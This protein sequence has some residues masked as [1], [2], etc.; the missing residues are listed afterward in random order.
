MLI[1]SIIDLFN[2]LDKGNI[3]NAKT[4]G[5]TKDLHFKEGQYNLIM[6]I[7]FIPYVVTA[8]FIAIL[9]K[10]YGPALSLTLM[11]ASFGSMTLLVTAVYNFSGM[12]ALRWFVGMSE[13]A[14]FPLV[15]Y[16]LTMFYRRTE[17]ARRLAIFYG[18]S[19]VANAFSGLLAFGTFQIHGTKL[20]SWRWLFVVEG[21]ATLVCAVF[22]YIYL[23]PNVKSVRFLSAE[24]KELAVRRLQVDSSSVVGQKMDLRASLRIFK[25]PTTVS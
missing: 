22:S 17:L 3:S 12:I 19:N 11:M 8:P 14:F 16:Y 7:F 10:K 23:P 1:M 15:I 18:A 6:S 25:S 2:S 13:A 24:E 21:A 5:M 4:A 20:Q 9:G